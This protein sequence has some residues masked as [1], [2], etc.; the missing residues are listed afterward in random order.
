MYKCGNKRGVHYEDIFGLPRVYGGWEGFNNPS[1]HRGF[2]TM[3]RKKSP[4]TE[5]TGDY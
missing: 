2:K 5:A 3:K 4:V 1:N